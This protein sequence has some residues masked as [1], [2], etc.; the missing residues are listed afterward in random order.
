MRKLAAILMILCL[1]PFAALAEGNMITY[2][3]GDFTMDFSEDMIGEI[4]EKEENQVFFVL[5]PDY[6]EE[7]LFDNSFTC[8]WSE[9]AEDYSQEDPAQIGQEILNQTVAAMKAQHIGIENEM[10]IAAAMDEHEGKPALAIIFSYDADYTDA[11]IDLKTTLYTMQSYVSDIDFG[12]Y[13]FS[14]VVD[15]FEDAEQIMEMMN[16]IHWTQG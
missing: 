12:S 3:F 9:A 4:N 10:L 13:V 8:V 16:T 11:G 15:H 7:N 2:D 1:T 14:I 6:Q 5:Y